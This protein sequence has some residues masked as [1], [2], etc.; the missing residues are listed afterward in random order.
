MTIGELIQRAG[1]RLSVGDFE[2]V[3]GKDGLAHRLILTRIGEENGKRTF[4]WL[5]PCGELHDIRTQKDMHVL[6][7]AK[8]V[9]C[10]RCNAA[11]I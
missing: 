4:E 6:V 8:G 1:T 2:F 9:T 10:M 11:G 7:I 5:C 3:M